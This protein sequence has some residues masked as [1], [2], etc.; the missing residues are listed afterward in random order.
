MK[1]SERIKNYKVEK[2]FALFFMGQAGFIIKDK[3]GLLYAFDVYLTDCCER[4]F[5]F[6]RLM[7]KILSPEDAEFDYVFTTHDHFDHYD[8]DAMPILMDNSK[9]K[10]V[11]TPTGKNL[12]TRQG[13][14]DRTLVLTCGQT[15]SVGNISVTAVSCDH[16]E[17]AKDALGFIIQIEDMKIYLVGDS[18]FH[19]EMAQDKGQIDLLFVPI[20]GAF[21]NMNEDEAF[22][23]TETLKAKR[24]VPCH[25]GN[26]KEHGGNVN[27]FIK[28]FANVKDIEL[29]VLNI[30]DI[31]E[32]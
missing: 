9:C 7:P 32:F 26:F 21:G 14:G 28:H 4:E 12:A 19:K 31:V 3:Q 15:I 5:G 8:I 10:L 17:L 22:L 2:S 23:F 24:V 13:F 11:T 30:G 6:K 29:L 20:N 18:A 27:N 25:Y 16:G 1:F